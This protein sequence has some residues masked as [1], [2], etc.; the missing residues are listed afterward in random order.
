M[1]QGFWFIVSALLIP[2]VD[3]ATGE[4]GEIKNEVTSAGGWRERLGV[5][6]NVE[7]FV[8]F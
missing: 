3:Y 6:M 5:F 8:V 4:V 1:H 2:W 7:R